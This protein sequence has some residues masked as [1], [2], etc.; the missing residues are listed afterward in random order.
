MLT[1]IGR[2]RRLGTAKEGLGHWKAQRL[3][4]LANIILVV[5]FVFQMALMTGASYEE[6]HA[7]FASPLRA[8]LATLV[9]VSVYY[10]ARLGVQVILEDYVHDPAWKAI[11]MI[12]LNLAFVLLAVIALI[13][14]VMIATGAPA[15]V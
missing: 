14:I 12:A 6:W 2:V 10:H 8:A 15:N 1:A 3:T 4:A 5:W 7:W 9:I 11:S 13:S